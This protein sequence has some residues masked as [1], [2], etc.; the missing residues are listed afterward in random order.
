MTPHFFLHF[1]RHFKNV[2]VQENESAIKAK[3]LKQIDSE[4]VFG[5]ERRKFQNLE[6]WP[7]P[8]GI[9]QCAKPNFLSEA[10]DVLYLETISAE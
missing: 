5:E 9:E 3:M 7:F 8:L 6:N 10:K 2:G 4:R 1:V